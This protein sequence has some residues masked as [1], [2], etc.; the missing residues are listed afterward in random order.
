MAAREL[1]RMGIPVTL[2]ESGEKAQQGLLIRIGGRNYLRR[3]PPMQHASGLVV[4]GD[5][6]TDL[7]TNH[8]LGGLSN[9]WTG[10]VPRF[11]AKD[12]AEGT[13]LHEKYRWPVTYKE[14]APYYD[15]AENTMAISGTPRNVP[16]L[17]CGQVQ[18]SRELPDDWRRI[19]DAARK[20]GQGLTTMPLA[21]GPPHLF[22]GR[23]TAF[24]SFTNLLS[25]LRR[26]RSFKLIAGAHALRL[27]LDGTKK[28]AVAVVYQ[29][30][31]SGTQKRIAASAF[32]IACGP[33]NSPKL[34]FNSTCKD[35]PDGLGNSDGLLGKYLHDHPREWWPVE[36][37]AP[38]TW[39]SPPAY[40]TRLPY[41]NSDPLIAS[42]W[43]L[44]AARTLDKVKSQFGWKLQSLGV[45][46]F[47]TMVP[48][49]KYYVRP[50]DGE[51]DEFGFPKLSV[52]IKFD[53]ATLENMT[54]SR[55]HLLS[56]LEDAGYRAAIGEIDNTL[57]PGTAKH[58]G[59][60]V[61][62][63][64]SRKFGV[65]D[66]YNRLHDVQ[67]VSVVDASC[68]TTGP[69]KNPTI[70]IMALAARS[71]HKLA[72]QLKTGHWVSFVAYILATRDQTI[73][74]ALSAV[75]A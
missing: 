32:V 23:G 18:Y 2:L 40:L 4:T 54:R 74:L 73:E 35:F 70:T 59:G 15:L 53:D 37:D 50:T 8:A 6:N 14:L 25:K 51:K 34:L 56:L 7:A 16:N 21:D 29:H 60:T 30:R 5:P 43:T 13:E 38:L 3:K 52:H 72:H 68:F 44:G 71:A 11:S 24:N 28:K 20:Q 27:E 22:V 17:P 57:F 62:M 26:Q 46:V 69:E 63:H 41:E 1:V 39:P 12:F 10:A 58:F 75:A 33:L 64:A 42:S 49:E 55:E 9:Q 36:V 65:T 47:G 19:A 45:Q 67:N 31:K 48:R 66:A 61:R